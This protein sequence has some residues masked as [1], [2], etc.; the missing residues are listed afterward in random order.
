VRAFRTDLASRGAEISSRGRPAGPGSVELRIS[1]ELRIHHRRSRRPDRRLTRSLRDTN[2][3][4]KYGRHIVAVD[5]RLVVA[6]GD[7]QKTFRG[8]RSARLVRQSEIVI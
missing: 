8:I 5:S 2:R 7:A 4:A 1:P 6:P 3:E